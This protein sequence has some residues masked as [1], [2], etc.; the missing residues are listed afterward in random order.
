MAVRARQ[1]TDAAAYLTIVQAFE[2][3]EFRVFRWTGCRSHAGQTR[4]IRIGYD[5]YHRNLA[6]DSAAMEIREKA[7]GYSSN[8]SFEEGFEITPE[9]NFYRWGGVRY[10]LY[11]YELDCAGKKGARIRWDEISNMEPQ[12]TIEH[13][14]PQTPD[15][16]YWQERFSP[17]EIQS[18]THALGNLCLTMDNSSYRNFAFPRK[19]GDAQSQR[20]CYAQSK[21]FSEQSLAREFQEWTPQTVEKRQLNMKHW[22]LE[23]WKIESTTLPAELDIDEEIQAEEE[24]PE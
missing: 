14:L 13:I 17:E 4:L 8:K 20:P 9:N 6:P 22:A 11:E 15:D 23:R 24:S 12:K 3:F 10:F 21:L 18:C 1:A 7:L 19:C 16:P 2:L 5:L